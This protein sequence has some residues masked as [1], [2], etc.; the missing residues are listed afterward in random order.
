MEGFSHGL[1]TALNDLALISLVREPP[2][3][4]LL[5]LILI[6]MLPK[7][8]VELCRRRCGLIY[9][10]YGSLAPLG[11]LAKS[12]AGIPVAITVHGL[13]ITYPNRIYQRIVAASLR[14]ADLVVCVS[15]NTR[16]ECVRRSIDPTNIRVIPPG[17]DLN[18][19]TDDPAKHIARLEVS[20][21]LRKSL[22]DYRVLLSVGRLIRRK[23]FHWF[24]EAVFPEL[25]RRDGPFVYLIAGDG[26]LRRELE[27]L[28]RRMGFQ[29]SVVLLGR[30]DDRFLR[31]LYR[32]ADV[33]VMPNIRVHGNVE[34]FGIVAL[35]ASLRGLPI[36]ANAVDG[37]TDSV[38]SDIAGILVDDQNSRG[39]ADAIERLLFDNRLYGEISERAKNWVHQNNSWGAIARSYLSEFE[40]LAKSSRS[41][42]DVKPG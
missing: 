33:F 36:V 14:R 32:T 8:L 40:L 38:P 20:S 17:I 4:R 9:L 28:I 18:L 12:L 37:L 29:D 7:I 6:V 5:P 31:S 10:A 2:F 21:R 39:F 23:G 22:A 35:E 16:D 25:L 15:R 24:I 3:R 34:G 26:P 41:A 42:E 27:S 19:V 13:D 11:F 30:V 1:A